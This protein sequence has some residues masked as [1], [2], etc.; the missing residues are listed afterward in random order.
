MYWSVNWTFGSSIGFIAVEGYWT[1]TSA[2]VHTSRVCVMAASP[3]EERKS[4]IWI[5]N[6]SCNFTERHYQK[7][8]PAETWKRQVMWNLPSLFQGPLLETVIHLWAAQDQDWVWGKGSSHS[9]SCQVL[10]QGPQYVYDVILGS[11]KQ[12]RGNYPAHA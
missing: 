1:S 4:I 6:F 10:Q 8:F 9:Q 11:S 7:S 2:R 3:F 5:W 12:S